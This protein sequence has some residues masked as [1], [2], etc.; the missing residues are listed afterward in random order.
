MPGLSLDERRYG[1]APLSLWTG[2]EV[3]VIAIV[4]EDGRLEEVE[5]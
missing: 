4:E 1:Y 3:N 5:S 2:G